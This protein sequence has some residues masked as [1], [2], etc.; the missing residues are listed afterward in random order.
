MQEYDVLETRA[1]RW[2]HKN[3]IEKLNVNIIITANMKKRMA[4][5]CFLM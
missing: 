1:S 2:K 3:W 4:V 5:I